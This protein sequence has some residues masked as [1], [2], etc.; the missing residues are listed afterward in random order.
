[1]LANGG[2]R[3]V[4]LQRFNQCFVQCYATQKLCV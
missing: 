4:F 1:L 3:A 2:S